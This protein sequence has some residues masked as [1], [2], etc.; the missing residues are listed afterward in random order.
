MTTRNTNR[1]TPTIVT[2][3][4]THSDRTDLES[5]VVESAA[6]QLRAKNTERVDTH[7]V[8]LASRDQAEQLFDQL[9]GTG[10]LRRTRVIIK[11]GESQRQYTH[12]SVSDLSTALAYEHAAEQ[13]LEEELE[14]DPEARLSYRELVDQFQTWY[15]NATNDDLPSITWVNQALVAHGVDI[16]RT[17]D[18]KRVHGWSFK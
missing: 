12:F 15:E 3:K 8:T 4:Q 5:P 14:K 7:T 11:Y 2:W 17:V 9:V 1:V 6:D 10:V 16:R 18:G 13:F